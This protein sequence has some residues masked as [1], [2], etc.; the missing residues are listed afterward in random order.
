MTKP[1]INIADIELEPRRAALAPFGPDCK[2]QRFVFIARKSDS[3]NYREG[4]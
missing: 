3:R 2:P 4:E 1:V